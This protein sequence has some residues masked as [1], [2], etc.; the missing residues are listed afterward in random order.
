MTWATRATLLLA[1]PWGLFLL[2]M[3]APGN[4]HAF[5]GV[6]WDWIFLRFFMLPVVV[7]WVLLRLI[8]GNRGSIRR[9]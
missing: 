6:W 2:A 8:L 5:T 9:Y 4:A 3:S 7:V 1:I